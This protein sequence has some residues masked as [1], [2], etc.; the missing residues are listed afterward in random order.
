MRDR[1]V[2]GREHLEVPRASHTRMGGQ[3]RSVEHP[4]PGQQLGRAAA[5]TNE[6]PSP[7][8]ERLGHVHVHEGPDL[9]GQLGHGPQAVRR[10]A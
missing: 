7:L 4:Q 8:V 2:V 5:V 9:L 1:D 6:N 3:Y 10:S